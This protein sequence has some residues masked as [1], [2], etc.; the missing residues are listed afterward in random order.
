MANKIRTT[1]GAAFPGGLNVEETPDIP[2]EAY[3]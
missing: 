3:L 1:I 2:I